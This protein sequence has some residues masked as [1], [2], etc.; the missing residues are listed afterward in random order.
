MGI[1]Q[2]TGVPLAGGVVNS[3]GAQQQAD[4]FFF[5][6]LSTNTISHKFIVHESPY[7][8][9][10]YGLGDVSFVQVNKVYQQQGQTDL[11]VPLRINGRYVALIEGNEALLIDLPG[12]YNLQIQESDLGIITVVGQPTAL[13]YWSWGLAAYANALDQSANPVNPP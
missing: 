4:N 5:G 12:V 9:S 10:A 13:A 11:V 7:L 8:I 1:S 6:P 3:P 2:N